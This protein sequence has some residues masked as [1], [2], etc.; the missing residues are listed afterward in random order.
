MEERLGADLGHVRVHADARAATA[1]REEHAVAFTRGA[2][3]TFAAGMY[4]PRS[5]PGRV[6]LAHELAHVVQQTRRAGHPRLQSEHLEAEADVAAAGAGPILGAASTGNVQ[7]V[8][9]F[10]EDPV[11]YPGGRSRLVVGRADGKAAG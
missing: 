6:V 1:A 4:E 5:H 7:R 2:D 10:S 3:V 8:P 9:E 11:G